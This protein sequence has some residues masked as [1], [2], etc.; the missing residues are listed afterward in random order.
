M[1]TD[2]QFNIRKGEFS[3]K[4]IYDSRSYLPP[5]F[6]KVFEIY[7]NTDTEVFAS[8]A[9]KEKKIYSELIDFSKYLGPGEYTIRLK[10]TVFT[11]HSSNTRGLFIIKCGDWQDIGHYPKSIPPPP[12]PFPQNEYPEI[13]DYF[14]WLNTKN[15][16]D[17]IN[18]YWD[19]WKI[20]YLGK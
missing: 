10:T 3:L 16:R 11:F 15:K 1:E 5:P 9:I 2:I 19:S 13:Q 8:L 14:D 17:L 20:S 4:L 12:N 7:L 18:Q 6:L